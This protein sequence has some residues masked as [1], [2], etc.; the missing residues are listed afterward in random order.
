MLETNKKK[1]LT[2][3]IYFRVRNRDKH[4]SKPPLYFKVKEF[5]TLQ[6]ICFLFI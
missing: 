2:L 1:I 3:N 6:I 4:W 5:E